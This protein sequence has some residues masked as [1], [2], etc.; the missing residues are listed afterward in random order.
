METKEKNYTES[1][2]EASLKRAFV[3]GRA[4]FIVFDGNI[5]RNEFLTDG[6]EYGLSKGWLY[7]GETIDDGQWTTVRY[8]LSD[9]GKEYFG[10]NG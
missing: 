4:D 2:L 7:K 3:D 1:D 5:S 8:R 6:I 10:I 9:Q